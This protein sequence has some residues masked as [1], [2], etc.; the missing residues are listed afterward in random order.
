MKSKR[1]SY[2]RKVKPVPKAEVPKDVALLQR[3]VRKIDRMIFPRNLKY[4]VNTAQ[5]MNGITF[6]NPG[7][8]CINQVA[9]GTDETQRIGDIVQNQWIELGYQCYSTASL[10]TS[11]AVRFM[12]IYEGESALGSAA[13]FLGV[14]NTATPDTY[15]QRNYITRNDKRYKILID[16]TFNLGPTQAAIANVYN[17]ENLCMPNIHNRKWR[18]PLKGIVTDYSRGTTAAV[19]SIEKGTF[20]LFAITDNT[21]ASA[22]NNIYDS[23]I[24]FS[25]S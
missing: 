8:I 12:L 14:F 4:L 23:V 6:A 20:T 10:L 5:T 21:T 2:R 16:E 25:D 1:F 7:N 15:T 13:Q 3:Q 18:I 17:G 24:C 22:V 19:T 11:C 9:Q